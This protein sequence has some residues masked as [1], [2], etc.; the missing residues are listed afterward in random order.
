MILVAE[1]RLPGFCVFTRSL[2][3]RASTFTNLLPCR[4]SR[5]NPLFIPV[6][7]WQTIVSMNPKRVF[8]ITGASKGIGLATAKMLAARGDLPVGIARNKVDNFPGEFYQADL[9]DSQSLIRTLDAIVGKH[10]VDGLV[11]NVGLVRPRADRRGVFGRSG[12]CVEP[13][14]APCPAERASPASGNEEAPLGTHRQCDQP[15][16]HRGSLPDQLFGSQGRPGQLYPH[17][18]SGAGAPLGL[19][20]TQWLPGRLILNCLTPIILQAV[21]AASDISTAFP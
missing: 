10:K 11:N 21:K 12:G 9:A 8:V 6:V 3:G 19:Q 1:S 2:I 17:L 14:P 18:G 16:G 13:E 7:F 5:K 4:H 20:S 15:R